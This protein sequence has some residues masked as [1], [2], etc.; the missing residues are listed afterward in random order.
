MRPELQVATQTTQS[1]V[2]VSKESN[3]RYPLSSASQIDQAFRI[4]LGEITQINVKRRPVERCH[5]RITLW[6][7]SKGEPI[8]VRLYL[9][10]WK[11]FLHLTKHP[12]TL[13]AAANNGQ[14]GL[15]QEMIIDSDDT[16]M[17][18]P[19][20]IDE[21]LRQLDIQEHSAAILCLL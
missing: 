12:S 1:G 4:H 11:T 6:R 7:A 10:V 16:A 20:F 15:L 3:P 19:V 13:F 14:Y 5:R 2:Q 8:K 17:H 21:C 18:N 9:C